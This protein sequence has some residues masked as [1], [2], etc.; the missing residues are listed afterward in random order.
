VT[1]G[2]ANGTSGL[3]RDD[4]PPWGFIAVLS[5]IVLAVNASSDF[6]EMQ[7]AD[8][9]FHWWEPVAWEATSALVI[10]AMAPLIGMAVRRWRPTTEDFLRPGLIHLALTVPFALAHVAGIYVLRQAIYRLNDVRYGYFEDGMAMVLFY[11]WRKDVLTYA[12][13]A[14]IYWLFHDMRR[15]RDRERPADDRIELRDGAAAVWLRAEDVTHVEAAG[16]YV[17]FH[18]AAKTHLVRATLASWEARL[19]ARG[20][21]RAHRSRLINR[22]RIAGLKPTPS[23]DIEISLDD[24]RTLL[25]SR[26]YRAAFSTVEAR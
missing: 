4:W 11:E 13:I 16:N 8:L 24:G 17:E 26:R 9:D 23:G 18:T 3:P 15:R 6:L 7:R 19:T 2:G 21:V 22:A 12:G 20:F 25:G 1:T 14:A 5:L 10:V